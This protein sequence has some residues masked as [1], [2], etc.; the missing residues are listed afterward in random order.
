MS[1]TGAKRPGPAVDGA[2]PAWASGR[3]NRTPRRSRIR[4]STWL[5]VLLLLAALGAYALLPDAPFDLGGKPLVGVVERVADGDTIEISGQRIR[6]TGL[7][8][9][10][11]DQTC[12]K[13]DGTSWPCGRAATERMRELT[14]GRQLSC[15]GEGHDKYGRL[16]ATCLDGGTD[17]A[18]AMVAD[19]LA[20]ASGGYFAAESSAR[21][22]R[23][24]IWQGDFQR[25]DDWRAEKAAG[26]DETA[27]NPS[28]FERFLAWLLGL[29]FS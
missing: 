11:R 20:V 14:R 28:R 13:S 24:G 27:G 22:A 15:R 5:V 4:W 26:R 19:G 8:A 23:R 2:M 29:F 6:L 9:P 16:L 12:S 1:K 3:R 10:E 7:D 21:R 17:L 25:P 18:Q